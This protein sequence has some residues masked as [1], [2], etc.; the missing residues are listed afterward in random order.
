M[1]TDV[2]AHSSNDDMRLKWG[3]QLMNNSFA[4]QLNSTFEPYCTAMITKNRNCRSDELDFLSIHDS[5]KIKISVIRNTFVFSEI[6]L[7][8]NQCETLKTNFCNLLIL[9]F[10]YNYYNG[11]FY[12]KY[13]TLTQR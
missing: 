7:H 12:S 13:Q 4:M 5:I 3:A 2:V 9:F 1:I 6:K 8:E 11:T 10:M